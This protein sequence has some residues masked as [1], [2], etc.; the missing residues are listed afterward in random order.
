MQVVILG[1]EES[2][3]TDFFSIISRGKTSTQNKKLY[4]TVSVPDQRVEDLSAFFKPKKTTF[5]QLSFFSVDMSTSTF[6]EDVKT[7]DLIVYIVKAFSAYEGDV[8]NPLSEMEDFITSLKLK[9]MEVLERFIQKNKKDLTKSK[10]VESAGHLLAEIEQSG[11]VKK[12]ALHKFEFLKHTT[13]LSTL[14]LFFVLNRN[15]NE[16]KEQNLLKTLTTQYPDFPMFAVSTE[17]EKELMDMDREAYMEFLQAYQ[18]EK[19]ALEILIQQIYQFLGLITFFTVGEDEV[20]AWTVKK[21][22]NAFESAGKIHTDIQ[23]G[24]IRAEIVHYHD[25]IDNHFS[26]KEAKDKGVFYLE[27]KEYIV[28]DG[29]IMHVRFNI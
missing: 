6:F 23:K 10:E 17:I 9:D 8:V 28:Q 1:K 7:A 25:F 5:T 26:F 16:I 22:S 14:P 24:F 19:P 12:E 21:G 4:G 29:D 18:I 11:Q 20:R 2:K 13:L 3:T 15:E 27:G